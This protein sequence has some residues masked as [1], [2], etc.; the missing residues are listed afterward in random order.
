MHHLRRHHEQSQSAGVPVLEPPEASTLGS[1]HVKGNGLSGGARATANEILLARLGR[2]RSSL[3]ALGRDVDHGAVGGR[4][5]V[6]GGDE[7]A[8]LRDGKVSA[9]G[10]A[11]ERVGDV[12]GSGD[13]GLVVDL[14]EVAVNTVGLQQVGV[15]K[16]LVGEV[17]RALGGAGVLAVDGGAAGGLS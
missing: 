15:L 14:S 3:L 10:L 17:E 12:K 1:G 2:K 13:A 6:V 4:E 9:A 16:S 11:G 7:H 5:G 8:L